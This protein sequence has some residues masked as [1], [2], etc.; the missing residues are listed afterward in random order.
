[1]L[2]E[3]KDKVVSLDLFEK[4]FVCD[5]NA[6]KGA[7][8]VEGDSGAPITLDEID[9][10]ENDLEAI[11]P[12]MRPEGIEA[13][14]ETGVFYLDIENEPVTTL[15][16]EKECAFVSFD[17]SGTAKCAIEQA[18]KAG[19]TSFKKPVSCHLYPIRVQK[20]HSFQALNYNEW[21]ICKPACECG[22]KLDV[23]V[24][25]FL[26]EPII[27]A[28]GEEFYAEMEIINSELEKKNSE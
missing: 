28:F 10:L 23:K 13:V 21:N 15:I 6:C 19:K 1:M 26:K 3:V 14:E 18:H 8:C 22:T 9:L 12:F 17:E 27:R 16:N 7:C 4:R 2:I 24:Y 20:Y 25:R 11:K 5:L